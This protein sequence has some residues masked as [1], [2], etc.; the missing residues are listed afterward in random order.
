[1]F[2]LQSCKQEPCQRK[3]ETTPFTLVI[4]VPDGILESADEQGKKPVSVEAGKNFFAAV[5]TAAS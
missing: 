3:V 1:M 4:F 5:R 2:L